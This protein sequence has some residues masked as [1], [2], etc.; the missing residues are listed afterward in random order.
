MSSYQQIL[1]GLKK[2]GVEKLITRSHREA[3]QN[4]RKQNIVLIQE[5]NEVC[6]IYLTYKHQWGFEEVACWTAEE[7]ENEPKLVDIALTAIKKFCSYPEQEL[8]KY[9]LSNDRLVPE[10]SPLD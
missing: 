3:I 9:L 6:D 2:I 1:E 5:V 4:S 8:D 10:F 7:L